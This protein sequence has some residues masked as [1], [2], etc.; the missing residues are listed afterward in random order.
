MDIN[1]MFRR[2]YGKAS[3]VFHSFSHRYCD[4]HSQVFDQIYG[5][6]HLIPFH[7]EDLK[8]SGKAFST[9]LIVLL[10]LHQWF[11]LQ[12]GSTDDFSSMVAYITFS[13]VRSR[14]LWIILQDWHTL[15]MQQLY[16]QL[17]EKPPHWYLEQPHQF[18]LPPT[19]HKDA[20]R[21]FPLHNLFFVFLKVAILIV[22][23]SNLTVVLVCI[24]HQ[25][26]AES[27]S[28]DFL[29][30]S[31]QRL[32]L[33]NLSKG[34]EIILCL[35]VQ[36]ELTHRSSYLFLFF[37]SFKS[38]QFFY[39]TIFWQQKCFKAIF[40]GSQSIHTNNLLAVFMA[41]A[42]VIVKSSG[43]LKGEGATETGEKLN[44]REV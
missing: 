34:T 33:Y 19:M 21:P 7:G 25:E 16:F 44:Q 18:I 11:Y 12:A 15:V 8:S 14:V 20:C 32:Q 6:S 4:L 36:N 35:G 23:R 24:L 37:L 31:E 5:N 29:Q 43:C 28:A 3:V 2:H 9:S 41:G 22:V 40:S 17:F 30:G 39:T 13:A 1:I 42:A 10:L 27:S 38:L 26:P